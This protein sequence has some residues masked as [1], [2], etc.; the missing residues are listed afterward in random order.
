MFFDDL[1][2]K[3]QPNKMHAKASS[4]AV[5]LTGSAWRPVLQTADAPRQVP[6]CS[7][8]SSSALVRPD[9][10]SICAAFGLAI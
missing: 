7:A 4:Q 5:E 1:F 2:R 3:D 10:E 9:I 6:L 8:G